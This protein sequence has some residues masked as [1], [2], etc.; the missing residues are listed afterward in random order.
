MEIV[1]ILVIIG[2]VIFCYGVILGMNVG[3]SLV[4]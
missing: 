3:I 4:K 2:F 1:G